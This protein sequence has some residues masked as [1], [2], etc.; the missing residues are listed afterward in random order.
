M[1]FMKLTCN[2]INILLFILLLGIAADALAAISGQNLLTEKHISISPGAKGTVVVFMSAKCPCSNS[3]VKIMKTLA[4][5]FKEFSF[6]AIHSNS[7]EDLALSKNYFKSIDL[8]FPTLEDK[9]G[10]IADEFK[11]LKTPHA[12][13]INPDGQILYK[14]G[15]TS[16][17][18]GET[19]DKHFL[20]DALTH[21][22]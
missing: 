18:H 19:A 16:S 7:D 3:H 14:G 15:V 5:E 4:S 22:L 1:F 17:T 12:F 21:D 11:A 6:V 8:P 9:N 13:V 20:Q 10:K 2:S